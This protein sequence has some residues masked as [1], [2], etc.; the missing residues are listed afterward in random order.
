MGVHKERVIGEKTSTE[1][2][3]KAVRVLRP[4]GVPTLIPVKKSTYTTGQDEETEEGPLTHEGQP[5]LPYTGDTSVNLGGRDGSR[6]Q[7]L[8]NE[9]RLSMEEESS[10]TFTSV[11]MS[12]LKIQQENTKIIL[13]GK[14][15]T[16]GR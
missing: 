2:E 8:L 16:V 4:L 1:N 13:V 15:D 3:K 7:T 9:K 5:V 10:N 14:D 6:A 12:L 11:C